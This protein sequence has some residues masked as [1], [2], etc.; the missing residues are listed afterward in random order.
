[1]STL[2][3]SV[4]ASF[5]ERWRETAEANS[6]LAAVPFSRLPL[7][8]RLEN[9]AAACVVL[10]YVLDRVDVLDLLESCADTRREAGA[11]IHQEWLSRN[12][13]ET[14]GP[15]DLPFDRLTPEDQERDL[16]QLDVA[17]NHVRE[18]LNRRP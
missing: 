3:E 4:A 16:M 12:P 15:H 6:P 18:H 9:L 8:W 13:D 14:G 5:H 2:A 17:I 10:K 1:M 11:H 7:E